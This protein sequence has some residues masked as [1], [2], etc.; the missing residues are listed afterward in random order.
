VNYL[1]SSP[2]DE[3]VFAAPCLY[4]EIRNRREESPAAAGLEPVMQFDADGVDLAQ[5]GRGR[6]EQ[7]LLGALNI[8]P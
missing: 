1:S 2:G 5:P 7:F 8:P 4:A 6:T 3:Y